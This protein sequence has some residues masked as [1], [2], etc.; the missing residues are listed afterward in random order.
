MHAVL[1]LCVQLQGYFELM[2]ARIVVAAV[3]APVFAVAVA[4]ALPTVIAIALVAVDSAVTAVA[5]AVAVVVADALAVVAIADGT[6]FAPVVAKTAA[7]NAQVA[8]SLESVRPT[9]SAP[10]LLVRLQRTTWTLQ[11][12]A[13]EEVNLSA[14]TT[15]ATR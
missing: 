2:I 4:P 12:L 10:M 14:R 6:V 9:L 5:V 11:N 1:L 8:V 7:A 3:F 13:S 15:A